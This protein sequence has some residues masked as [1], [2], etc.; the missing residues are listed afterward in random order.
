MQ[1]TVTRF[2]NNNVNILVLWRT[3]TLLGKELEKTTR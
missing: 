3:D 1:Q 2:Y